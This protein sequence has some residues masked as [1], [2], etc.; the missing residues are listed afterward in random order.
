LG[1][2]KLGGHLV[3]PLPRKNVSLGQEYGGPIFLAHKD[4]FS[5]EINLK[6][7]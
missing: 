7:N 3:F 1:R 4:F 5:P 6:L 2:G